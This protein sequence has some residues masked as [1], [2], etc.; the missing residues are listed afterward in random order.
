M[1]TEKQRTCSAGPEAVSLYCK[2]SPIFEFLSVIYDQTIAPLAFLFLRGSH[3]NNDFDQY[4]S[5]IGATSW[6]PPFSQRGVL[7]YR[8]D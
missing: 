7:A 6:L 1:N 8:L 2:D 5:P 4:R 3:L